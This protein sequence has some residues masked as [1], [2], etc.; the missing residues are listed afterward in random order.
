MESMTFRQRQMSL[1][2]RA[3]ELRWCG[4]R[5]SAEC[6]GGGVQAARPQQLGTGS[7]FYTGSMQQAAAGCAP[8]GDRPSPPRGAGAI[9]SAPP[10]HLCCPRRLP[11]RQ[12]AAS[13][14]SCCACPLCLLQPLLPHC[15]P[16]GQQQS[17][18]GSGRRAQRRSAGTESGSAPHGTGWPAC[19]G[20]MPLQTGAIREVR[21]DQA[22]QLQLETLYF[23]CSRPPGHG[24]G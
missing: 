11:R 12:P 18:E 19:P 6:S 22:P 2:E 20:A 16:G 4:T 13:A 17:P 15:P 9:Q 3:S 1:S 7:M 8:T 24:Q 23:K 21:H 5:G 10:R 14:A